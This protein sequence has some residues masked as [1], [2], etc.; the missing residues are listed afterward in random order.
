VMGPMIDRQLEQIDKKHNELMALN[1]KLVE[2]FQLYAK[3][4]SQSVTSSPRG[5]PGALST[6]PEQQ[7]YST[8]QYGQAMHAYQR[9]PAP[10]MQ[11]CNSLAGFIWHS[12]DDLGSWQLVIL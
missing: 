11:V 5:Y 4:M 10:P 12:L 7:A 2:S 8:A 6:H 1:Q 3:L 9:Q